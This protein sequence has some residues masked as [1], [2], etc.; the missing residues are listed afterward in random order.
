MENKVFYSIAVGEETAKKIQD[1]AEF[2][3]RRNAFNLNNKELVTEEDIIKGA[4]H[5]Y[6]QFMEKYYVFDKEEQIKL[7]NKAKIKNR[8]REIA[9]QQ[10][11][12]QATICKLTGITPANISRVFNNGNQPSIDYFF[13]IWIALDRPPIED[14]FYADEK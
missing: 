1:C 3:N 12:D 11:V 10:G 13:R 2:L 8:F 6:F 14:I 5:K 7:S 4:I 9:M